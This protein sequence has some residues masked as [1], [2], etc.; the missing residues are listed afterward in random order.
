MG[1]ARIS[2]VSTEA[3]QPFLLGPLRAVPTPETKKRPRDF[4]PG[5]TLR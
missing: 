4:S 1:F 2:A 5:A 3:Q